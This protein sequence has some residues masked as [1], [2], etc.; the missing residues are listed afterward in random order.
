MTP[1][2]TIVALVFFGLGFYLGRQAGRA[3]GA[4][5][6]PKCRRKRL[7]Y[8]AN[9]GVHFDEKDDVLAPHEHPRWQET[10]S[11]LDD[12]KRD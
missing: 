3:P 7:Y 9:C 10:Q 6:C 11:I 4:S 12:A 5:P 2:V 1:I 8:C